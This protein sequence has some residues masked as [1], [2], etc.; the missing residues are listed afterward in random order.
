V[1]GNLDNWEKGLKANERRILMTHWLAKA[2]ERLLQNNSLCQGC[3]LHTGMLLKLSPG[4][5]DEDVKPQGLKLPYSIP[6]QVDAYPEV[7]EE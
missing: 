5:D 1:D 4:P 3:F 7:P 2:K 6:T